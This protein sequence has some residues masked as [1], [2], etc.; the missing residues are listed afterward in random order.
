MGTKQV[1]VAATAV[2]L[3]C[4]PQAGMGAWVYQAWQ[5]QLVPNVQVMIL[6]T[7]SL[8]HGSRL[9]AAAVRQPA[10]AVLT[11]TTAAVP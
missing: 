6:S 10:A 8:C 1:K 2:K 5:E 4:V 9:A 11:P 7:R 3:F